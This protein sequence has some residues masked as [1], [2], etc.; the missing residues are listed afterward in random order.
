LPRNAR[1]AGSTKPNAVVAVA[2]RRADTSP[3]AEAA[4]AQPNRPWPR[5]TASAPG[6]QCP[7]SHNL[8]RPGAARSTNARA[9]ASSRLLSAMPLRLSG[10]EQERDCRGCFFPEIGTEAPISLARAVLSRAVASAG[11]VGAGD[12]QAEAPVAM[13]VRRYLDGNLRGRKCSLARAGQSGRRNLRRLGAASG[14]F[15]ASFCPLRNTRDCLSDSA[16][17]SRTVLARLMILR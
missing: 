15:G 3:A 6:R 9:S 5:Q 8:R 13:P 17:R 2:D 14:W 7:V 16:A 11:V 1:Q 12:W 10:S 4:E